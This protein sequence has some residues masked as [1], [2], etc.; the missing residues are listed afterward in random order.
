[1]KKTEHG[2]LMCIMSHMRAG[3]G[4]MQQQQ[5]DFSREHVETT[6]CPTRRFMYR[7]GGHVLKVVNLEKEREELVHPQRR[8]ALFLD[9]PLESIFSFPHRNHDLSRSFR[10]CFFLFCFPPM[11][12]LRSPYGLMIPVEV[13]DWLHPGWS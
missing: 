3:L 7:S 8:T 5:L 12:V 2:F 9:A 11:R 13:M 6:A 1:M 10:Y 4:Y